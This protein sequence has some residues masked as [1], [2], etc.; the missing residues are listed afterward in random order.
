M[1]LSHKKK[2]VSSNYEMINNARNGKWLNR[3]SRG[4]GKEI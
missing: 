3:D 4:R 1:A 2:E